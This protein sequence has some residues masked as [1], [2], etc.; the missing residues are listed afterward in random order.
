MARAS[1]AQHLLLA[2]FSGESASSASTPGQCSTSDTES[3]RA[4]GKRRAT[5]AAAASSVRHGLRVGHEAR[6]PQSP[7]A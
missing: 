3:G 4:S 7:P 1:S 6:A 5:S 2:A